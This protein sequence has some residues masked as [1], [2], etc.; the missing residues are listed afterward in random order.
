[1][2]QQKQQDFVLGGIAGA[3][4]LA[5]GSAA[6]AG[7]VESTTLPSGLTANG[8]TDFFGAPNGGP[9]NDVTWDVNGD[10][11]DDF[12]FNYRGNPIN[13]PVYT[14]QANVHTLG[15]SQVSG[16]VGFFLD[17]ANN[18]AMGV[19][20]QGELASNGLGADGAQIA[21]G[22]EY[23]YLVYGGFGTTDGGPASTGFIAFSFDNNGTTNYGWAEISVDSNSLTLLRAYYND[24]G[25]DIEN[26]EVP[27]PASL[28]ALALGG[29]ALLRRKR[30]AA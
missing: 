17:Y 12:G 29:G 27:A 7:I 21:L 4:V 23:Y 18:L 8:S 2:E 24:M 10:G 13:P 26:G 19:S 16:Y 22:S 11:T 3:M 1:M 30:R 28:G 5:A 20:V 14:W 9:S 6:Y 15:S 25:G